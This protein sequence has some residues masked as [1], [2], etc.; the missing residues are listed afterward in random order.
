MGEGS[1]DLYYE[2]A[3]LYQ[4]LKD[5]S[6]YLKNINLALDFDP[7]YDKAYMS[8]INYYVSKSEFLDAYSDA[9]Q[10]SGFELK[11]D[12]KFLLAKICFELK[13]YS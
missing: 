12:N 2:R 7:A 11:V 10:V 13:K 6:N 4:S 5:S 8:R 9:K 1:A 3:L